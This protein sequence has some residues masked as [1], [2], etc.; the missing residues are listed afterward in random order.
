MLQKK[1]TPTPSRSKVVVRMVQKKQTNKQTN[2]LKALRTRKKLSRKAVQIYLPGKHS[3]PLFWAS[4][5][6]DFQV[7]PSHFHNLIPDEQ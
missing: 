7:S 4:L 3:L 5:A 6:G 1:E 2:K